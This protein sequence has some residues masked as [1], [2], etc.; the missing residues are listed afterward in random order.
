MTATPHHQDRMYKTDFV[1]D[2]TV[3]ANAI[4]IAMVISVGCTIMVVCV[5]YITT[6]MMR[7]LKYA[8]IV[9][10]TSFSAKT[11]S[12]TQTAMV[13]CVSFA[14]MVVR[15]SQNTIVVGSG[16]LWRDGSVILPWKHVSAL[17]L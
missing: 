7:W 6:M 8:N 12:F 9:I 13:V 4:H 5:N 15:H 2:A 17:L 14:A 11:I 3:L 10:S 16:T 1:S